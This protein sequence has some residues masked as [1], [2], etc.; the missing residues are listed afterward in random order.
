MIYATYLSFFVSVQSESFFFCCD[1]KS[2]FNFFCN[3]K[4]EICTCT[5][6]VEICTKVFLSDVSWHGGKRGVCGPVG[7]S[8]RVLGTWSWDAARCSPNELPCKSDDC[9]ITS[10]ASGQ[11]STCTG[12]LDCHKKTLHTTLLYPPILTYAA[13]GGSPMPRQDTYENAPQSTR[14]THFFKPENCSFYHL[15]DTL[16]LIMW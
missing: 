6:R 3:M 14:S 9:A 10:R 1:G 12:P 16:M 13:K 2:S 4:S 15:H 5:L 7:C 8:L 11:T